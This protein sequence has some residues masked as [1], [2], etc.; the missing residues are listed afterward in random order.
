[1][2][3][4]SSQNEA[5]RLASILHLQQRA[6]AAASLPELRFMVL[7]ETVDFVP[8]RQAV[9]FEPALS[10]IKLTAASGLVDVENE[11]PFTV[12]MNQFAQRFTS[13]SAPTCYAFS[14]ATREEQQDWQEWLPAHLLVIPL[15]A[16]QHTAYVMY[17]REQAWSLDEIKQLALLHVSY[18]H[19]Y[20]ALLPKTTWLNHVKQRCN[21]KNIRMAGAI[22]LLVLCLPV[23]LSVLAPAEVI[24]LNALNIASPQDGVI[25]E[26]LVKPN[27]PVKAD[28]VLFTLDDTTNNNRVE[29]AQKALQTAKAEALVAEQRAI[30]D[31]KSKA[32]LAMLLGKVQEKQ[33]ELQAVESQ[34]ARLGVL[35]GE[36]GLAVFGDENDWIG[37]PVQTGERVMQIANPASAGLL[38]WLPTKDAIALEMGAP[39]KLFLDT[40]PLNPIEASLSQTSYQASLS[41]SN[42]SSYRLKA[43]FDL[44]KSLPR[45]GLQGTARITGEW[46]ILAY[47]LFRKPMTAVRTWLGV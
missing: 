23:R 16:T 3:A 38:I 22:L 33:A 6:M 28:D 10:G 32:D 11:S 21:T 31:P 36:N 15:V 40:D 1:M 5:L 18:T 27:Q 4:Q 35:A 17:A 12:W 8:Y 34:Q 9:F 29:V 45:I 25:K 13:I 20:Q 44:S 42:V 26:I 37:R 24:A 30:D 43:K 47:Y 14:E 41:P 7:N 46:S 39:V 19:C 2:I